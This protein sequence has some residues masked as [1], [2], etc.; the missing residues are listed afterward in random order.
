MGALQA[1]WHETARGKSSADVGGR[2]HRRPGGECLAVAARNHAC[3]AN[4][5]TALR[6]WWPAV[7]VDRLRR[8]GMRPRATGLRAMSW[9]AA[10]F[11]VR[12]GAERDADARTESVWRLASSAALGRRSSQMSRW[13]DPT[14]TGCR[15]APRK[16]LLQCRSRGDCRQALIAQFARSRRR[17]HRPSRN[18]Q[19]PSCAQGA[20]KARRPRA[21]RAGGAE[22]SALDGAEHSS[23]IDRVMAVADSDQAAPARARRPARPHT[24]IGSAIACGTGGGS[25]GRTASPAD[26][27]DTALSTGQ[28]SR[29]RAPTAMA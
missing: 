12:R 9:S 7:A 21:T 23:I 6:G 4:E 3:G 16:L 20:V 18:C 13:D 27:H 25:T 2:R 14:A 15:A 24:T 29:T 11:R 5:S 10:V 1:R 22:R 8:T 28:A 17:E 26:R 19:P